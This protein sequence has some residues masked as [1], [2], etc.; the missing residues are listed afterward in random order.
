MVGRMCP[1]TGGCVMAC[2]HTMGPDYV[3]IGYAASRQVYYMAKTES[4]T[5][6]PL[7]SKFLLAAGVFPIERG[8][9]DTVALGTQ[10][11]S[12]NRATPSACSPREPA[13]AQASLAAGRSGTTR[14]AMQTNVPLVPAI[15]INGDKVL[16]RFKQWKR[17]HIIVRFGKP[18]LFEGDVADPAA[19]KAN[20]QQMMVAMASLLPAKQRG[21][22][23][24]DVAALE[25]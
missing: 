5:I 1:R 4:F 11:T 23:A 10:S 20:T 15:S 21:P 13:A 7:L 2:N 18:L 12:S 3:V 16:G 25:R 24:E 19:V 22:Y 9:R 8:A 14:I 17:P 6:N